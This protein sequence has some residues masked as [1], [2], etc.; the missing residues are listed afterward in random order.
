MTLED[1]FYNC[2]KTEL[3]VHQALFKSSENNI[4]S[5]NCHETSL[6]NFSLDN[7][8][9]LINTWNIFTKTSILN[10]K[11]IQK[12]IIAIDKSTYLLEFFY[13]L[14]ALLLVILTL[15]SSSVYY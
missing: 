6:P 2:L 13:K 12:Q 11:K 7:L 8:F 1:N 15:L 14:A 5:N 3:E 10:N 4:F 9:Q